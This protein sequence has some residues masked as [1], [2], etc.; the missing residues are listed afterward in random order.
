M[1]WERGPGVYPAIYVSADGRFRI[2]HTHTRRGLRMTHSHIQ[3][4]DTTTGEDVEGFRS[5]REAKA[6]AASITRSRIGALRE[7]L[8][9]V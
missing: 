1:K 6:S 5:V 7:R 8:T 4:V 3:L 2:I 9:R